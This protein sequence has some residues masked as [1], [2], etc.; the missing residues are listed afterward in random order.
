M[1]NWN[2]ITKILRLNFVHNKQRAYNFTHQKTSLFSKNFNE[3]KKSSTKKTDEKYVYVGRKCA[4]EEVY[5]LQFFIINKRKMM[6]KY[7]KKK[8]SFHKCGET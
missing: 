4:E 2:S 8:K 6:K 7:S 3:M 5:V 1:K